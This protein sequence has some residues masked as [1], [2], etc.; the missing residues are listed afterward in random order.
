RGG[1]PG[2]GRGG[3]G[4]VGGGGGG[5]PW[6]ALSPLEGWG[7]RRPRLVLGEE[8]DA[9]LR[10]FQVLRA[11]AGEGHAFLEGLQRGLQ[12][13]LARLELIPDLPE[14]ARGIPQL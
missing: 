1:G 8:L 13:Q 10:L 11:A 2:A 14:P 7:L 6:A 12:R 4:P 5:P 3:G 9:L